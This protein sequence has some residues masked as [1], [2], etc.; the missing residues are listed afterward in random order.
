M[1]SAILYLLAA[2]ICLISTAIYS[3]LVLQFDA[4]DQDGNVLTHDSVLPVEPFKHTE[5]YSLE[6]EH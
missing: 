6:D 2:M 5:I 4:E 3:V 1:Y